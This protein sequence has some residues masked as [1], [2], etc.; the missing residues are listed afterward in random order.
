MKRSLLTSLVLVGLLVTGVRA[1]D[2]PQWLGPRRDGVWREAG[3]LK[4]FPKDG[5]KVRWRVPVGGGYASAAVAGGKVFVTDFVLKPGATRPKDPFAHDGQPGVER[6]HCIEDSS[7]KVLWT[8]EYECVYSVSYSAGPRAT[9]AV[10]GDRVYTL[11]AEGDLMCLSVADGGVIWSKK[12]SSKAAPTPSW[13]YAGHPLIDGNKVIVGTAGRDPENGMGAVTAFDKMTGKQIWSAVADRTGYSPP[14]IHTVGK[15]RQLILW[16][17]EAVNSVEPETGKLNWSY[18]Y[19]PIKYDVAITTPR[20]HH[21]AKLGDVL[22]ITSQAE[23]T[24]V[25][26]LDGEKAAATKLWQRGGTMKDSEALHCLMGTPIARDGY[27][28]GVCSKGELRGLVLVTGDRLWETDLATNYKAG[29]QN[30]STAFIIPLGENSARCLI[31]N[32]H[33]D[34]LLAELEAKGYHELSRTHLLDPTNTDAQRPVIWSHP[35]LANRT[36]Y[37]RNDKELVAASMAE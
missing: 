8:R 14:M 11:G 5:L 37:W 18:R 28:Y 32:E 29:P 31:A 30:W 22:I 20:F 15:T 24:L 35:A 27:F 33:G 12:L 10:D 2:W 17:A 16:T 4:E 9:P 23:G 26:K 19:G 21:D 1:D 34:L 3:L 6:V 7:G 25:L 13:G 36:V